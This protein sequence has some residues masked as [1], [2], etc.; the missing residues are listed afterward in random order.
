MCPFQLGRKYCQVWGESGRDLLGSGPRPSPQ[1]PSL[2][3]LH[4]SVHVLS[5]LPFC[6]GGSGGFVARM[7][8]QWL[9]LPQGLLKKR[10]MIS[11]GLLSRQW[12]SPDSLCYTNFSWNL[13]TCFQ[14]VPPRGKLEFP[15][16]PNACASFT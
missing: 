12:L 10:V 7:G 4:S 5:A 16:G 14:L 3:C 2:T 13:M 15:V 9:M 6:R 11:S 8:S 1:I